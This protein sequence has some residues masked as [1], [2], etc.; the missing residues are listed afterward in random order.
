MNSKYYPAFIIG[1]FTIIGLYFAS[2][3]SGPIQAVN[4]IIPANNSG[5]REPIQENITKRFETL[6]GA[7][8]GEQRLKG[9]LASVQAQTDLGKYRLQESSLLA[10]LG[11]EATNKQTDAAVEIARIN[12]NSRNF[13]IEQQ[14][15]AID[16]MNA[17]RAIAGI[18]NSL[19]NILKPSSGSGA[20][21]RPRVGTPPIFP[22]RNTSP[23]SLPDFW[24]G[25]I[26]PDGYF[27][28]I[29]D[30]Y[31]PGW[32]DFY[33]APWPDSPGYDYIDF[34]P[35]FGNPGYLPWAGSG[36]LTGVTFEEFYP[37]DPS[38]WS[39]EDWD[40]WAWWNL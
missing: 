14:L 28:S 11:L 25:G 23:V 4:R 7:A 33:D 5:E 26:F 3:K 27:P 2:R 38:S 30:S 22:S 37:E 36:E 29:P 39:A 18:L 21:S 1:I 8:L 24:T 20:P 32:P 31:I 19:G 34:W 40:N 9:E 10:R 13:D 15:R 16:R 35:D 17:G 12:A 6:A